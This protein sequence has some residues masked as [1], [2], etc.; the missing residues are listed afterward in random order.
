MSRSSRNHRSSW[1]RLLLGTFSVILIIGGIYSGYIFYLTVR[2]FV[3]YAQLSPLP[4]VNWPPIPGQERQSNISTGGEPLPDWQKKERVNVLLLGIDQREGE[5]GPWRTDTM[6][7]LTIDPEN[8]TAGMLSIP[9]DLWVPI[10]GYSQNRI[11]TAH[12]TGELKKYPGGGPALAIKTVQHNLGIP[13]HY[14]VR[15]NFSGFVKAIDTI[16]GVD[17]YVEKEIYD[18]LYPDNAYGYDPLYIPAGLHHMDGEL[19]L[20]YA[21]TRHSGSD[22]DRLRCQQQVIMAVRDK[23]LRLDL[24]PQLLP[25]LP[26]LLKTVGD[27]VQT[28]LQ[29]DELL[30]LAQVAGQIDDEH[31]KTAVIDNSM[32][33]PTTTPNGAQVLIPI[34]DEV[35]AVVDEIFTTP[36]QAK[37]EIKDRDKLA[38]E[39]A[40]IIVH[41]GTTVGNLAA[42]TSAFLKEQGL[43]IVEFGNAERFDYPTTIIVDYTGK[44]Y[45][46]QYLARLLNISESNI[47]PFTGSHSEIDIRLIIGADFQLPTAP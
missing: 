41:N 31:I 17:I 9:R 11:N 25:K 47:Q 27:A 1:S 10:P 32:T 46:V 7:V 19:A 18:P 5:Y 6:I 3:A 36:A 15:I 34:P 30:N 40:K 2:D 13:I 29:P 14:Y 24:L 42:Q 44:E 45:T 16:G 28:D 8:N 20:K 37:E 35:R 43:Q 38:A 4:N 23:V 26:E 22:F 12:Y 21:R 33:V 39:G